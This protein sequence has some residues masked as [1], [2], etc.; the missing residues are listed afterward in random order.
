[1]CKHRQ[2][3]SGGAG[4]FAWIVDR[5]IRTAGG[6][7]AGI[8]NPKLSMEVEEPDWDGLLNTNLK[9][10]FFVSQEACRRLIAAKQP[11]TDIR[12]L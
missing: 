8:A 5:D 12:H 9:G 1:M 11:G 4:G 2:A 6:Q 7:V 10:A 3:L